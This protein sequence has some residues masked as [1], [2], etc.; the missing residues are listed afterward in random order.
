MNQGTEALQNITFTITTI[1]IITITHRHHPVTRK[2]PCSTAWTEQQVQRDEFVKP[3]LHFDRTS[4][5]C[6]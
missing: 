5:D 3:D 2:L 6:M 4:R 1:I